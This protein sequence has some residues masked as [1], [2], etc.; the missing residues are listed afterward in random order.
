MRNWAKAHKV[1]ASVVGVVLVFGVIGAVTGNDD[2]QHEAAVKNPAQS[3]L[4]EANAAPAASA[5]SAAEAAANRAAARAERRAE[6]VQARAQRQAY[7]MANGPRKIYY[8]TRG[9]TAA[10]TITYTSTGNGTGQ[11]TIQVQ[12]TWHYQPAKLHPGDFAQLSAQNEREYGYVQC[13]IVEQSP[14]GI[15]VIAPPTTGDGAFAIADC[16][17][18]VR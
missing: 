14:Y 8:E 6:R 10:A 5:P 17:G 2:G 16:N 4:D 12:P 1:W 13:R 18:T 7:R 3:V 9:T 15:K 11:R